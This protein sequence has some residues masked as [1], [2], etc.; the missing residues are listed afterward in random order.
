MISHS[1]PDISFAESAAVEATLRSGLLFG[2]GR[3]E[4]F[5]MAL[6]EVAKASGVA[7]FSSGRAAIAAGLTALDLAA[8]GEVIV[9]T[10]VCDA[11]VEAI[12]AA[13]LKAVFCDIGNGWVAG[14]DEVRAVVT[15][16]SVAILL[17]PPFGLLSSAKAFRG[18][19][20]P[21]LHDLCQAS[22]QTLAYAE[23]ADL[24]DLVTLSFHPTKYLCAGGGGALIDPHGGRAR[25]I[26]GIDGEQANCAPFSD[27]QAAI[28][29]AQLARLDQF[30]HRRSSLADRFFAA[31]PDASWERLRQNCD[32]PWGTMFRL[33][34]ESAMPFD[35][36]QARFAS[37]GVALRHGVD[38]LA[39][40]AA[41]LP[42]DAFPNSVRAFLNTVS[43]PFYPALSEAEVD[44]I[45]TLL[46][47]QL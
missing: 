4:A 25:R 38:H 11:V 21:I 2:G 20:L 45:V 22:P 3:R 33:P 12:E 13:G 27:L 9:Q 1:R 17:A 26:E 34:F 43:A 7:L 30:A 18:I 15:S 36:L 35:E 42:D 10:Y 16:K 29:L 14:T 6:S 24:G 8:E 44:Q 47:D 41:G 5:A 31:G 46:R 32:S 40:R 19:G 39:H 23:R 37:R 28:G